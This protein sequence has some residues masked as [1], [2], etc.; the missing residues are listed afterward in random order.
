MAGAEVV[1]A[2]RPIASSSPTALDIASRAA[3]SVAPAIACRNVG[4]AS[5]ALSC[6]SA[7]VA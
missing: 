5:T 4:S 2:A 1:A 3:L 7:R 6:T